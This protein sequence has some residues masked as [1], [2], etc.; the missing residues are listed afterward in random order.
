MTKEVIDKTFED[1][2][3]YKALVKYDDLS[4]DKERSVDVFH[5]RYL[6]GGF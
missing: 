1:F 4:I 3:T 5:L 2:E 6:I